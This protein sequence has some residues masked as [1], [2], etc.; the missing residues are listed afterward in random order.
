[1]LVLPP[2][3]CGYDK[4]AAW[5]AAPLV[6]PRPPALSFLR[7]LPPRHA[8]TTALITALAT[9]PCRYWAPLSHVGVIPGAWRWA[10]PIFQCPLDHM[11]NPA[12][13][14]ERERERRRAHARLRTSPAQPLGFAHLNQ[15]RSHL[16]I[17][18]H[19]PRRPRHVEQLKPEPTK[20]IREYSFLTNPS[21]APAYREDVTTVS[22]DLG[23]SAAA[24]ERR[25]VESVGGTHRVLHVD[26]LP[27]V[28]EA[29]WAQGAAAM[30]GRRRRAAVEEEE[31]SLI[32]AAEWASF[33]A[34]FSRL[35]GG[36]CCAP[37][38][39]KPHAAGFRIME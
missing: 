2:L 25:R 26:N 18:L 34:E 13:V 32:T 15:H 14:R 16:H 23:T 4:C 28:A 5:P 31:A 19:L 20:H 7:S 27:A 38:G 29:L 11:L 35:Q 9:A 3:V 10:V 36:W 6:R 33:K 12:E 39:Q 22:L 37:H 17:A 30:R 1:M 8:L 21:M 24:A